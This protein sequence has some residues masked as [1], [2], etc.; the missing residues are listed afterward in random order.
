VSIFLIAIL[1]IWVMFRSAKKYKKGQPAAPS[2]IA[3]WTEPVILFVRDVAKDNIAGDKYKKFVPYLLTVFFFILFGNI[4][5]LIPFL[6]N[7]N[8][9][10]SISITI[11]LATFTFIIQLINS[12]GYFWGHIFD[13]LGKSMS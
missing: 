9:T 5:G 13:P 4:L 11:L 10:G 2:G 6:A 1:L 12:K 3:S 7:P 8:V